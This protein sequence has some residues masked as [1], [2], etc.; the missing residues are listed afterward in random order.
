LENFDEFGVNLE[1]FIHLI[2][3][4][5]VNSTKRHVSISILLKKHHILKENEAL[6]QGQNVGK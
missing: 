2:A 5:H 4:D 6:A 3:N 1:V